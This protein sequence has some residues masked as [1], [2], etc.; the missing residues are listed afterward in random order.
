MK[1]TDINSLP[2]RCNANSIF[3]LLF[4][5]FFQAGGVMVELFQVIAGSTAME[6]K[7]AHFS[8]VLNL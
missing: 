5:R 3:S 7:N 1:W 2:R 8:Q 6:K 4:T